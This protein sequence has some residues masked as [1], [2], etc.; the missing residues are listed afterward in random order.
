M[1]IA[2]LVI[3]LIEI[4]SYLNALPPLRALRVQ[5]RFEIIIS[6]KCNGR[7]VLSARMLEASLLRVGTVLRLA[8][9]A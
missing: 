1:H 9:D 2:V 6:K 5:R 3:V 8:R 4:C 7:N